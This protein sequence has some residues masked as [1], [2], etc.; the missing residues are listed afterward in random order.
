VETAILLKKKKT[1]VRK[2]KN[3]KKIVKI[4]QTAF[5]TF[6]RTGERNYCSSFD[7]KMKVDGLSKD[8]Y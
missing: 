6:I 1:K 2:N 4:G 3:W 8:F 7:S 5:C